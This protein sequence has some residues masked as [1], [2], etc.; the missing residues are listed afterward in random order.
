MVYYRSQQRQNKG[1][2]WIYKLVAWRAIFWQ[3][4]YKSWGV[5]DLAVVLYTVTCLS[6]WSIS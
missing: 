6:C 1:V 5:V 3:L 2:I 4:S